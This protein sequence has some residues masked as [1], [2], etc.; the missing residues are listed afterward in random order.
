M[1]KK[2]LARFIVAEM[3]ALVSTGHILE[4]DTPSSRGMFGY[5]LATSIVHK[6][7][8]ADNFRK[9]WSFFRDLFVSFTKDYT[10]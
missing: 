2:N 3:K 7:I 4:T 6:I 1:K 8:S 9:E 5:E 10:A